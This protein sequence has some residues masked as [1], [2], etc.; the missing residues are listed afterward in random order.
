MVERKTVPVDETNSIN[1]VTERMADGSWAVVSSIR[2]VSP[3]GE[4]VTDL[5]VRDTRYTT[6]QEAE[7][8]GLTQARD[9]LAR[10]T[11]HA[12]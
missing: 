9:W 1:I 4:K 5:P 7:E 3:G 11:T 12:A 6:E 8:A 2:H 10:N